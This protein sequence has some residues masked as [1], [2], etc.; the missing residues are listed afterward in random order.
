MSITVLEKDHWKMH[1]IQALKGCFCFCSVMARRGGG[2]NLPPLLLWPNSLTGWRKKVQK[3]EEKQEVEESADYLDKIAEGPSGNLWILLCNHSGPILTTVRGGRRV[4]MQL[5]H[6][7]KT[8]RNLCIKT[9]PVTYRANAVVY[10]MSA[11]HAP[12]AIPTRFLC[13]DWNYFWD[14]VR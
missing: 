1:R 6:C 10:R 4:V 9:E 3:Q 11:I 12:T 2:N 13:G 5:L 7:P 14:S 8:S